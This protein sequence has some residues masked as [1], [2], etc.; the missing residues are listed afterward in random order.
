LA[1][2]NDLPFVSGGSVLKDRGKSLGTDFS[3]PFLRELFLLLIP[4]WQVWIGKL[5]NSGEENCEW[6]EVVA[7]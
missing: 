3:V 4:V 2:G 1:S 6:N 5:Q 7:G